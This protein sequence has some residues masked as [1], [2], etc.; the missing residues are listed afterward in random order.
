M[1]VITDRFLPFCSLRAVMAMVVTNL[2]AS[3]GG[4]TW[5][6]MD[7]RLE[8]KWSAIGFCSGAISGLVGITRE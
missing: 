7:W 4:L 2:A 3:V 5:M 6:I 1:K 8:R